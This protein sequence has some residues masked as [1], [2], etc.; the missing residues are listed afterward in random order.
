MSRDL[1]DYWYLL[2]TIVEN[3]VATMLLILWF[4]SSIHMSVCPYA[5]IEL[6]PCSVS[7]K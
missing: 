3:T 6:S 7:V 4:D 1:S 5:L 2:V